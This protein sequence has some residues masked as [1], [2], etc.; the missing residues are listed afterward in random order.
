MKWSEMKSPDVEDESLKQALKGIVG[1]AIAVQRAIDGD[2]SFEGI[3]AEVTRIGE[4]LQGVKSGI[5]VMALA[6][7]VKGKED[8]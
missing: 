1:S 8:R 7:L 5:S 6:K 2:M 3:V 4:F